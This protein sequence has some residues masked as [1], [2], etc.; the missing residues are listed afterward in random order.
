MKG[1]KLHTPTFH[2]GGR[3]YR[4]GAYGE[5]KTSRRGSIGFSWR[6][7]W[8]QHDNN[9]L[10]YKTRSSFGLRSIRDLV[11]PS[12]NSAKGLSGSYKNALRSTVYG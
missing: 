11:R 3:K 5:L 8:R 9:D 7:G 6:S 4:V 10:N 12:S 2:R 1:F